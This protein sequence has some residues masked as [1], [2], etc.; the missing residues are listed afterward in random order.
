MAREK[1][2]VGEPSGERTARIRELA[3]LLDRARFDAV[4]SERIQKD[5]WYKLWGNLTINP[6]SAVTGATIDRIVSDPKVLDF[7]SSLMR[8]ARDI[9]ERMGLPIAEEPEDGL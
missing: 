3:A 6:V 2:I 7:I 5:T 1:L 8:E 4:A 9:G